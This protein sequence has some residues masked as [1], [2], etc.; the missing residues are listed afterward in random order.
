MYSPAHIGLRL[1]SATIVI[2]QSTAAARGLCVTSRRGTLR[3][4]YAVARREQDTAAITENRDRL[5]TTYVELQVRYPMRQIGM[6]RIN[7]SAMAKRSPNYVGSDRTTRVATC[8]M[9]MFL[10]PAIETSANG[11]A[12]GCMES[13]N[14]AGIYVSFE[15]RGCCGV[16]SRVFKPPIKLVQRCLR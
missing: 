6:T 14:I 10:Q 12:E 16:D 13:G 8:L 4:N 7:D 11:T 15:L 2:Y 3:I 5:C 9:A 1:S